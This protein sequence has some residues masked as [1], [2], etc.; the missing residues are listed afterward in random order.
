MM[1]QVMWQSIYDIQL[2]PEGTHMNSYRHGILH[3]TTKICYEFV[4]HKYYIKQ[5]II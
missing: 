2:S 3:I 5:R 1:W 4:Q